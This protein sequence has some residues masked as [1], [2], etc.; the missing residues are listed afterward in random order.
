MARVQDSIDSGRVAEDG[1]SR[2][3]LQTVTLLDAL[4]EGRFDAAFGCA[5][6][7]QPG[8][9][10]DGRWAG[11]EKLECGLHVIEPTV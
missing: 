3:R 10:R 9:G 5:P 7:T 6:C 4:A 8:T 1:P 11:T 2:N